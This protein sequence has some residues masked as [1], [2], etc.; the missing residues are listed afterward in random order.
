MSGYA[1]ALKAA[2][3]EVLGFEMAGGWQGNWVALL[4]V[5]GELKAL[6][7]YYGSCS[8]CDAYQAEFGFESHV[9]VDHGGAETWHEPEDPD[10][11]VAGCAKCEEWRQKLAAFGAKYLA[12]A[13]APSTVL[14]TLVR[15]ANEYEDEERRNLVKALAG[16]MKAHHG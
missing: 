1:E 7:G 4:R 3:A 5:G 6:T 8:G 12:V 15:E 13:K 11:F 16:F 10:H 9:V 2:G 14:D